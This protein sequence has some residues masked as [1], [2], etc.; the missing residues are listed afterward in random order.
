MYCEEVALELLI[1]LSFCIQGRPHSLIWSSLSSRL[2]GNTGNWFPNA[3]KWTRLQQ[4]FTA[5]QVYFISILN[6]F[7][8]NLQNF[9]SISIAS[10]YKR[11]LQHCARLTSSIFHWNIQIFVR[12][13]ITL[14]DYRNN[15]LHVTVSW[16]LL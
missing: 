16:R 7:K 12:V 4:K 13:D 1:F 11:N 6:S 5:C 8:R 9:M 10:D 3:Q 2:W 14:W 15:A